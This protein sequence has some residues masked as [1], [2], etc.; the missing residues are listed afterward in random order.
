MKNNNI[1]LGFFV[2]VFAILLLIG[3]LNLS[4]LLPVFV[5]FLGLSIMPQK[6]KITRFVVVIFMISCLSLIIVDSLNEIR[7]E[8]KFLPIEIIEDIANPNI[9]LS[10]EVGDVFVSG[11][12][13]EKLIQGNSKTN[14]SEAGMLIKDNKVFLSFE[15]ISWKENI[16]NEIEVLINREKEVELNI[17]SALSAINIKEVNNKRIKMNSFLSDI[18]LEIDRGADVDID[19]FLSSIRLFIPN[20]IGIRIENNLLGS[21]SKLGNLIQVSENIFQT[22]DYEEMEEKIDIKLNGLFSSFN[23][24]EK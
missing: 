19:S 4:L 22:Q 24:I 14:F 1:F 21:S 5:V 17:D 9:F 6:K 13:S 3:K 8:T 11:F 18:N 7:T 20:N 23:I 10:V 16:I 15:G 2:I 12:E